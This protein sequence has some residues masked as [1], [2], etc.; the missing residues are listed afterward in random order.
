M[1]DI[2]SGKYCIVYG[3]AENVT[4][5]KFI[6]KLKISSSFSENLPAFVVDETHT[7]QSWGGISEKKRRGKRNY[8][9]FRT[10][11]GKLAMLRSFLKEEKYKKEAIMTGLDWIVEAVKQHSAEMPRTI[12]FCNTMNDIGCVVNY[13]MLKLDKAAYAPQQPKV[14]GNCLVGIYHS[15][16][17][18][19][20]KKRVLDSLKVTS[21]KIRVV[22]A[23]SA[24]SMGVN[25]PSITYIINFG[26]ARNILEQHQE[27]GRAGRDELQSHA[28]IIYHGQQLSYCEESVKDF[29]KTESCLRVAGYKVLDDRIQ[30]LQQLHLCCKNCSALC[31][32][33]EE[34]YLFIPP[35]FERDTPCYLN[36]TKCQT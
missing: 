35:E 6:Q 25:F 31:D 22:V 10:A 14:Q 3:S 24:L 26:P 20:N 29:V 33:Q 28:R 12:I 9:A 7:I 23:S 30:P 1:E 36:C 11:Y 34:Q 19:R 5:P 21:G 13:L 4:D 17:W 18:E 32:C 2:L 16:S 27:I 8:T 15:N